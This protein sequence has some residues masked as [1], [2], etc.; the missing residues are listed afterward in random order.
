MLSLVGPDKSVNIRPNDLSIAY[1]EVSAFG[2]LLAA[3]I[4]YTVHSFDVSMARPEPVVA[5][6]GRPRAVFPPPRGSY[7]IGHGAVIPSERA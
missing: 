4:S 6:G 2:I 3:C 7:R 5:L 1:S